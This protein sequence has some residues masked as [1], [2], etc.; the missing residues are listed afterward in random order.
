MV[1]E[2]VRKVSDLVK[3]ETGQIIDAKVQFLR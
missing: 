1:G 3:E 2:A